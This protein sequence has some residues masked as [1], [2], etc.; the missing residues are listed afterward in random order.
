[1]AKLAS[2]ENV[3]PFSKYDVGKIFIRYAWDNI[4]DVAT[5]QQFSSK[6]EIDI[7]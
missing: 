6:G 4:I 2:G 1:L 3:E 7:N 5:F